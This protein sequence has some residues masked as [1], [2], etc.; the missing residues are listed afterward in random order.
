MDKVQQFGAVMTIIVLSVVA[1]VGIGFGAQ[2]LWRLGS[3]VSPRRGTPPRMDEQRLQRL[4]QAIDAIAIEV[5]RISEAQRFSAALLAERLPVRG[6]DLAD[7][8]RALPTSPRTITP[9]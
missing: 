9:H 8:T 6:T 4:E 3:R 1:F 7:A 5:E 2:F